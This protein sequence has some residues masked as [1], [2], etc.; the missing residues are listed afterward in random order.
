MHQT[1]IAEMT[2]GSVHPNRL[3]ATFWIR[4]VAGITAAFMLSYF[5]LILFCIAVA[6]SITQASL[7]FFYLTPGE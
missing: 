7:L 5:A 2:G 4:I 6:Y 1:G 3:C